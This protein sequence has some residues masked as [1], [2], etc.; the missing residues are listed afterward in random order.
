MAR[1]PSKG[2]RD[3]IKRIEAQGCR[4]VGNDGHFRVYN[5]DG[6]FVMCISGTPSSRTELNEI[7]R[8]RRKGI[9]L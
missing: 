7:S 2:R 1:L 4:V 6:Q 3:L 9:V 5:P 8:L